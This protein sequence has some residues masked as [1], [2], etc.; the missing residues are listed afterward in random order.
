[1]EVVEWITG[2]SAAAR[3]EK[4]RIKEKLPPYNLR[5]RMREDELRAMNAPARRARMVKAD[6]RAYWK[7]IR[8]KYGRGKP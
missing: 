2:R 6:E 3:A 5:H 1:M 7:M 4:A 8:E